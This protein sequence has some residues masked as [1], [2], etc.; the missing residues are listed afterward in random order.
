MRYEISK[1]IYKVTMFVAV[2]D[3]GCTVRHLNKVK[4][5]I[6]NPLPKSKNKVTMVGY[7]YLPSHLNMPLVSY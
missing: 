7:T 3:V 2:P 6:S 5:P 4:V 1:K